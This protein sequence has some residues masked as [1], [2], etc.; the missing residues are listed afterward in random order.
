M[1]LVI[2]SKNQDGWFAEIPSL[3][4]CIAIG[5]TKEESLHCIYTAM[6]EWISDAQLKSLPIPPDDFN[7]FLNTTT[8]DSET[9]NMEFVHEVDESETTSK[10]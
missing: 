8:S 7:T 2:L 9:K 10:R 3:P 1:R 4:G 5:R 6:R